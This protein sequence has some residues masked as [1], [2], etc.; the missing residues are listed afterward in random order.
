MTDEEL[1]NALNNTDWI[2]DSGAT[3]HFCGSWSMFTELDT[4]YRGEVVIANGTLLQI[5]GR[6]T[7]TARINHGK[8]NKKMTLKGVLWV[9]ELDGNLISVWML[10]KSGF[11]IKFKDEKCFL[12]HEGKQVKIAEF[13]GSG[14]RL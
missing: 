3:L 5:M 1:T 9:P 10:E 12:K 6:G 2:V 7:A 11:V 13:D 8:S 4:S 14:Y